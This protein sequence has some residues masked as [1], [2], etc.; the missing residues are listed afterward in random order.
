MERFE[1]QVRFGDLDVLYK[2]VFFIWVIDLMW[3]Q[4]QYLDS[5]LFSFDGLCR[6][7]IIDYVYWEL[8]KQMEDLFKGMQISYKEFSEYLSY[9][10]GSY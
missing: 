6:S 9:I 1:Y 2:K 7:L 8:L 3:K 10:F 4:C 5:S